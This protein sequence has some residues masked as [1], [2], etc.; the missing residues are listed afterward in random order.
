MTACTGDSSA[1]RLHKREGESKRRS[2]AAPHRCVTGRVAYRTT[3]PT[4]RIKGI[5]IDDRAKWWGSD[6][7]VV[8]YFTTPSKDEIYFIAVTPEPSFHVE[9]WS[10][11]G[12]K[13]M[14]LAAF[15]GLGLRT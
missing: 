5:A 2:T 7:H 8:H 6:R 13:D 12:D 1:G 15:S 4:E 9:S 11:R 3:H 10:T 14:L